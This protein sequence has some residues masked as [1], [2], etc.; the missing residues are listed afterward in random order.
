[1]ATPVFKTGL[2]YPL[3]LRGIVLHCPVRG[4][5]SS[6]I[7]EL[8]GVLARIR[9]FIYKNIYTGTRAARPS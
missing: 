2:A 7:R 6:S 8:A 1:V 3:V 9:S 5:L 4:S